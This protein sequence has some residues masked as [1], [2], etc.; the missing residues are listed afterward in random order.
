MVHARCLAADNAGSSSAASIAMMAMTTSSSIKVNAPVRLFSRVI[1]FMLVSR[2]SPGAPGLVAICA[3]HLLYR[4]AQETLQG[5]S[6]KD[7]IFCPVVS[8]LSGLT[9]N[10]CPAAT[11]RFAIRLAQFS[12]GA[13]LPP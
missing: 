1:F 9:E 8:F 7:E 3:F 5:F 13:K 6:V 2:L 10:F 11:R 4:A 12:G